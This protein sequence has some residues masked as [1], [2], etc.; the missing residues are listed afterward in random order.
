MADLKVQLEWSLG[1]ASGTYT[2]PDDHPSAWLDDECNPNFFM[3]EDGNLACDCNRSK[4][5][6]LDPMPCGNQIQISNLRIVK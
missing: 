5:F 1:S 3:W 4:F 2:D 6:G